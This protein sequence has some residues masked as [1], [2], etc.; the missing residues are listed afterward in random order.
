MTKTAVKKAGEA[1]KAAAKRSSAAK[2]D[3][4]T[5][6]KKAIRLPAKNAAVPMAIAETAGRAL[7]S[8]MEAGGDVVASG[9]KLGK[10]AAG[11]AAETAHDAAQGAVELV[12]EAAHAAGDAVEAGKTGLAKQI[13]RNP[14][15]AAVTALGVG[16]IAGVAGRK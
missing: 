6:A 11:M 10:D 1:G 7:R 15:A 12:S 16:F 5:I 4:S 8:A 9:V 13:K 14:V 3:M 2:K